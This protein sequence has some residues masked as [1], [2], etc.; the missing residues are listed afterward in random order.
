M[1]IFLSQYFKIFGLIP[2]N[3]LPT[4][5]AIGN[6]GLNL[7]I[8]FESLVCSRAY[9]LIPSFFNSVITCQVLRLYSHGT[10]VSAPRAVLEILSCGGVGVI[11]Q[12]YI[13][14]TPTASAVRK[15]EPTFS[16]LRILSSTTIISFWDI[17][18]YIK[19]Y[20]Q[21]LQILN[22]VGNSSFS[23]T[24]NLFTRK[25]KQSNEHCR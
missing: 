13:L 24:C 25:Y 3:S 17:I 6:F 19:T 10:Y 14:E 20:E 8:F 7:K 11:P 22:L 2:L 16:R 4:I 5:N 23:N 21:Q 18:W 1:A 12:R 9:I 15:I